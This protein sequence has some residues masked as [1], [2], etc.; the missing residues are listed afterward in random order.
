[1]YAYIISSKD[2]TGYNGYPPPLIPSL[3]AVAGAHVHH[4]GTAT[5]GWADR[6]LSRSLA[7]PRALS[8]GGVIEARER[9]ARERERR[10]GGGGGGRERKRSEREGVREREGEREGERER[11]RVL[12]P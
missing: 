8:R 3:N 10:E 1:M 9:A 4:G 5:G 12:G 11:E 7:L 6:V 2:I